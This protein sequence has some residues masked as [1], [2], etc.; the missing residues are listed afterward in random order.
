[1]Q[2]IKLGILRFPCRTLN[3]A[4]AAAAILCGAGCSASTPAAAGSFDG[5]RAL[6]DVRAQCGFGPRIP[7]TEGHASAGAWIKDQ[8]AELG[9][10]LW[11][12]PFSARLAMTG[13]NV[14][15]SNLWALPKGLTRAGTGE[16]SE[17]PLIII[18]AHWDTR[19]WADREP[20]GRPNRPFLSANDGA[21]GVAIALGI[22][23]AVKDTPLAD[24]LVLAFFDAEDS[25][26]QN[27]DESWCLGSRHAAA[28]PPDWIR[29]VRL[30]INLDMVGHRGL[31]LSREIHSLRAE[32]AAM[33]RLWRTGRSL[34]PE[35]FTRG[36]VGPILDDHYPFIQ[37]GVPYIDLIGLPYAYWHRMQDTPEQCDAGVMERLALVLI[38]FIKN[39]L[40]T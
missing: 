14:K 3:R 18:S 7:G 10:T 1:M 32:P 9:W 29:R 38:E 37:A 26:I 13:A 36:T 34:A 40:G 12:Q 28:N 5:A 24:R 21:S 20:R 35:I 4:V 6:A 16:T 19:P 31:K 30:G 22:A 33:A 25:G 11:E 39:E 17:E 23:R 15:A 2:E 8:I 27:V